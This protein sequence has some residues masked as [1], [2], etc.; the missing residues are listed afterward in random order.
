MSLQASYFFL[1]DVQTGLGPFLAAYLAAAGWQAGH[2]GLVLTF[3]AAITVLLQT[4]AGGAV[5]RIRSK[6]LLLIG[7]VLMLG[8]GAVLLSSTARSGAVYVA[9]VL[10]GGAAPFLAPTLAALTMGITGSKF[11]DRQFGRNQSFNSAGNVACALL[12]AAVSHRYGNRAIFLTA[13]ALTIPTTLSIFAIRPD[14][15]DY[16]LARGG[17]ETGG[18]G[19]A[20]A[21]SVTQVL[22]RDH[23]LLMFFLC[24]LLFHLA[25][26]AML[27]ELGEML[28]KGVKASAAP[29]MSACI[30]VTQVVIMCTATSIG[31]CANVHGRK[32]LLLLGFSVLPIRA[33]LYTL[34][35]NTIGLIAIQVLDGV[36]NAIFGVVSILV[37]ADLTRGTGR[38]NLA[39]GAIA[40]AVGIGAAIS[41]T[42]GG[43][44]A[45]RYGFHASFLA[46]GAVA[47]L[48]VILLWVAVPETLNEAAQERGQPQPQAA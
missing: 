11:F 23:V 1:A 18:K 7:A 16:E 35:A 24:A 29:F 48:A 34:T 6:R 4:P 13:A 26:A 28:S 21:L 14:D 12:I 33:V 42:F 36:A 9:Q 47:L 27:P 22:L 41:N 15:I 3:G 30:I 10:I 17:C 45:Q 37:V 31:R 32:G 5:D 2:I 39:Q 44:L 46:L 38:F 20:E 19:Q 43:M 8:S 25:N 40:T